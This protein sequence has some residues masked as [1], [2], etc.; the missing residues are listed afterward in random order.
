ML[1]SNTAEIQKKMNVYKEEKE[2]MLNVGGKKRVQK[3]GKKYYF[4]L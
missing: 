4:T 2:E 3:R 1:Q